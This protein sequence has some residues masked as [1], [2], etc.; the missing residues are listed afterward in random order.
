MQPHLCE[1]GMCRET[2][3]LQWILKSPNTS[4]FVVEFSGLRFFAILNLRPR[5]LQVCPSWRTPGFWG[6]MSSPS[7]QEAVAF[8]GFQGRVS[9]HDR[10]EQPQLGDRDQRTCGDH[11]DY[12]VRHSMRKPFLHFLIGRYQ[13]P[14]QEYRHSTLQWHALGVTTRRLVQAFPA[15]LPYEG[16]DKFLARAHA[17]SNLRNQ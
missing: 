3:F 15:L 17:S 1:F 7:K 10:Q 12:S 11:R 4:N 9:I 16:A 13:R 5:F 14:L 6:L 2:T 8:V